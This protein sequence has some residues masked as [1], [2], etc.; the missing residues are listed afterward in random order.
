M[1]KQKRLEQVLAVV[2]NG[3]CLMAGV[4]LAVFIQALLGAG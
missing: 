4:A 1:F 3:L 2:G